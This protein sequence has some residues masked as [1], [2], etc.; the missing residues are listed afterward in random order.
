MPTESQLSEAV[1]CYHN[2]KRVTPRS[3]HAQ[4]GLLDGT[5]GRCPARGRGLS[6]RK[7]LPKA[8]DMSNCK[9]LLSLQVF[10]DCSEAVCGERVQ[11]GKAVAGCPQDRT[12]SAGSAQS[13][14]SSHGPFPCPDEGAV[15]IVGSQRGKSRQAGFPGQEGGE[16]AT[17]PARP[18]L[19]PAGSASQH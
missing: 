14:S 15:S 2:G 7:E 11:G 16:V 12:G 18:L 10:L 13:S 19:L 8:D 17:P 4:Q 1:E 5:V 3:L 9:H 6:R